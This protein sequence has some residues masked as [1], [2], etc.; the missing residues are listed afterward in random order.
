MTTVSLYL[1]LSRSDSVVMS[2]H[3][4]LSEMSTDI[5][6]WLINVFRAGQSSEGNFTECLCTVG[7]ALPPV[8]PTRSTGVNTH[9]HEVTKHVH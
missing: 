8:A 9:V 7:L 2:V 3:S 4:R 5:N 1:T 6:Q